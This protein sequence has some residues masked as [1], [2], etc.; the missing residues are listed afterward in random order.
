MRL[1]SA[2]QYA[3]ADVIAAASLAHRG[4]PGGWHLFILCLS[5]GVAPTSRS[6]SMEMQQCASD[7][8]RRRNHVIPTSPAS[9]LIFPSACFPCLSSS[10]RAA[11]S[12]TEQGKKG[13]QE[14]GRKKKCEI[15]AQQFT[16]HTAA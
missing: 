13:R 9:H 2:G 7:K 6:D 8:D 5:V 11:N 12:S 4:Q 14:E 16:S 3:L 1:D 15:K 10:A